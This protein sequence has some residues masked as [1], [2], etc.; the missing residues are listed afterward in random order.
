MLW[1][2]SYGP[3][4]PAF[5]HC[6]LPSSSRS[7]ENAIADVDTHDGVVAEAD[8]AAAGRGRGRGGGKKERGL[9]SKKQPGHVGPLF[10]AR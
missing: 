8:A 2:L 7:L 3:P 4:S 5:D 1:Q 9:P 10:F 6:T